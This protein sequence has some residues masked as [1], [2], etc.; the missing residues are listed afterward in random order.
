MPEGATERSTKV[1]DVKL[2][3]E[4]GSRGYQGI[5]DHF[6]RGDN[7]FMGHQVTTKNIHILELEAGGRWN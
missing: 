6:L 2:E 3:R 4:W 7:G 1:T 5:P